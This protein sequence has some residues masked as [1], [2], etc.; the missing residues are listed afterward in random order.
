LKYATYDENGS[1]QMAL[2]EDDPTLRNRIRSRRPERRSHLFNAK[3]PQ[4]ALDRRAISAVAIV[5]QKSWRLSMP[6][7]ALDQLLGSPLRGRTWRHRYVQN[8]SVDMSDHEKDVQS[9][10]QDC[11]NAEKS[12]AHIFDS[13]RL[14]NSR[15]PE[16]GHR[17]WRGLMYLATGQKPQIPILRVRLGLFFDPK[18]SSQQPSVG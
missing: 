7:A 1:T 2:A 6:S 5:N 15:H 3:M 14:R 16:D 10:E 4:A 17:L 13:C 9:L 8:F 11:S 18:A 12:Q